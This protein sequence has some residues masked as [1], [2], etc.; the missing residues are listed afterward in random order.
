MG[1]ELTLEQRDSE[2]FEGDVL[3]ILAIRASQ[4]EQKFGVH[5]QRNRLDSV[6]SAAP[7]SAPFVPYLCRC[8]ANC[9]VLFRPKP[10]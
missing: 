2:R 6:I 5:Y 1:D 10:C 7:I 4:R 8:A 9:A 3:M